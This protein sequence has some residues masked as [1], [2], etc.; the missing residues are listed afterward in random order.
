M[1][2]AEAPTFHPLHFCCWWTYRRRYADRRKLNS[3][4]EEFAHVFDDNCC[5]GGDASGGARDAD[6]WMDG[7][8]PGVRR[9]P[10]AD[11]F[12]LGQ[13]TRMNAEMF[14]CCVPFCILCGGTMQ[15]YATNTYVRTRP[16][17][18]LNH[19]ILIVAWVRSLRVYHRL[20][21]ESCG[22]DHIEDTP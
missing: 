20:P 6:G 7:A 15:T 16:S 17:C 19:S 18:V 14:K 12:H 8:F 22:C 5:D 13:V 9:T 11:P 10:L 3:T 1:W 21:V 2:V 4:L